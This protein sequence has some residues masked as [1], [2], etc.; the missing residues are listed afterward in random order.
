MQCEINKKMDQILIGLNDD[1]LYLIIQYLVPP[2]ETGLYLF[3]YL[4][5]LCKSLRRNL[6]E[7]RDGLWDTILRDEYDQESVISNAK[8]GNGRRS[9]KRLRMK[10]QNK[11]TLIRQAHWLIC[12]RTRFAHFRLSEMA[13]SKQRSKS[14]SLQALRR[15]FDDLGPRLRCNHAVDIGG[16][17]LVEVC[18]ARYVSERVILRCARY[19]IEEQGA[20]PNVPAS[21]AKF[22]LTPLCICA[23]RGMP[24]LVRF[25]LRIGADS[26]IE[27]SGR[28]RLFCNGSKTFHGTKLTP[29]EFATGMRNAERAEGA[30]NSTLKTL[31][32]CISIL[33]LHQEHLSEVGTLSKRSK[34]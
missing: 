15:L 28:F 29:L 7:S 6:H 17:F 8:D 20:L 33:S 22:G 12:H 13:H 16:T 31:N 5:V 26:F 1:V 3:Q 34:S 32:S 4:A 23:A 11:I 19:L 9:S 18:R 14:L 25:L 27:S 30:S 24:S 10:Q 21:G 2:T